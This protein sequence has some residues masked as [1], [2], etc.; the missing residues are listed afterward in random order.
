MALTGM[1]TATGESELS[2]VVPSSNTEFCPTVMSTLW[3][4]ACHIREV[5]LPSLGG[6][7]V[8]QLYV[9][10]SLEAD[11]LTTA[12]SNISPAHNVETEASPL[13]LNSRGV[14]V[15]TTWTV[16][17]VPEHVAVL[18]PLSSMTV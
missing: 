11:P 14:G 17:A 5:A 13:K 8:N 2:H 1:V 4:K 18:V 12:T 15:C 9:A 10:V 6:T 7:E 3:F 16:D